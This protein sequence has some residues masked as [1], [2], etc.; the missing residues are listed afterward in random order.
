MLPPPLS[1][2]TAFLAS[3]ADGPELWK[4]EVN[5]VFSVKQHALSDRLRVERVL[6]NNAC[7]GRV[8]PGT[9]FS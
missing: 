2:P 4:R 9:R 5:R 6:A 7:A 1:V 8:A 3:A